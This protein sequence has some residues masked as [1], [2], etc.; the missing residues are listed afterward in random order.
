MPIND[1]QTNKFTYGN[2][3]GDFIKEIEQLAKKSPITIYFHNLAYDGTYIID[4]LLKNDIMYTNEKKQ[5]KNTFNTL[6]SSLGQF[7]SIKIKFKYKVITILDSLKLISNDLKSIGKIFNIDKLDEDFNYEMIRELD[8]KATEKELK[9]L[10]N[11]LLIVKSFVK[12]LFLDKGLKKMTMSSNAYTLLK[13]SVENKTRKRFTNLFPEIQPEDYELLK[14]AYKGGMCQVHNTDYSG[15]GCSFDYNSMYPSIMLLRRLPFKKPIKYSGAY[16]CEDSKYHFKNIQNLTEQEVL[17]TPLYTQTCNISF[18]LKEGGIPCIFSQSRFNGFLIESALTGDII[19]NASCIDWYHIYKNY[20]IKI[21]S[22]K[23]NY[24]FKHFG[25]TGV[26][27]ESLFYDFIN[28]NRKGKIDSELKGDAV[29]RMFY[30][31][32]QN[33]VYGKFG[34][35]SDGSRKEPFLHDEKVCY[36]TVEDTKKTEYVPL[37]MFITS[38]ARHELL[39]TIYKIGTQ[40]FLYCDTDS[41]KASITKEEFEERVHNI[42]DTAYGCWGYEYTFTKCNH[43]APKTYAL[44]TEKGDIIKCA[45]MSKKLAKT[46]KF[47]EFQAGKVFKGAN[48][49]GVNVKGGKMLVKVDFTLIKR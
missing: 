32:N 18:K 26:E 4:Y 23:Y 9:Y 40:N 17:E 39:S 15:S 13:T 21:H 48:L 19:L 36:T 8:H 49:K 14:T 3:I 29:M 38:W 25:K 33:A 6:I 7:F 30:K 2:N 28:E 24:V 43:I 41:I 16:V 11:D 10:K 1:N 22:Y 5:P 42:H 45:G 44:K 20:H 12:K 27:K 37:A 34:T 47:E 31:L 46:L 35:S